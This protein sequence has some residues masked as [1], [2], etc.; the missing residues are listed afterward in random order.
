LTSQR[1]RLAARRKD[2]ETGSLPIS[3]PVFV[4][5]GILRRPHGLKGETLVTINTDFPERL[6]VKTKLY[7]GEDHL[8]VTIK[9]RRHHNDG[10]LLAFEEFGDKE[11]LEQVRN[12]PLFVHVSEIPALPAGE[13]YQHQ[14]LGLDVL[15][16]D[17]NA[18]GTLAEIL[19]T[20]AND[21]Y[22]VREADGKELLLPAIK[23]VVQKIDLEQRQ[24]TVRL[25]PGLRDEAKE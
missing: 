13:Y 21:V 2:K 16:E 14:L 9:S 10:M 19:S 1:R 24:I 6:K 8:P 25:L 20:G 18:L 3:E 22:V 15:E 5:V 11:A 23:D 7:L 4:Q 17:G 12:L